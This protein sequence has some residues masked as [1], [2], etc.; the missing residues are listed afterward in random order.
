MKKFLAFLLAAGML[1]GIA[2]CGTTKDNDTTTSSEK[3]S[4]TTAGSEDPGTTSPSY[5]DPDLPKTFD[6]DNIVFSFAAISDMH[7]ANSATDT[8]AKKL[9]NAF[10]QLKK[11]ALID[12]EDGLDAV[13]AVGD[14][15]DSGGYGGKYSQMENYKAVYEK[16]FS[17][18]E[19]PM[20][21]VPG[22][23]DV[24]WTG[25]SVFSAEYLNDIL[26]EDYFLT[27]IDKDALAD[28]GNRHCVVNG[29]HVL[30]LLPVSSNPVT[31]TTATKEW[32]DETLA[33]ITKEN[34]NQFVIVLTHPMIYNTVYGS[35]LGPDLYPGITNMW[36]TKD[37]T[38]ILS[39]YN[40]VV[41]FGGHLHFPLNDPRSI[42]QTSFTSLGCGSV[43]YMAIE[44]GGYEDMAGVTTMLDKEEFSQG[45]LVQ[46]DKNGNMRITRMDFYNDEIIGEDWT[47]SYPVSDGS[48]LTKYAWDRGDDENNAAPTLSTL[49]VT[50][51]EIS[52]SSQAVSVSFASG[53]DDEFVHH[54][55]LAIW[56]GDS[57]DSSILKSYRILSDFYRHANTADMKKTW[58][59]DLGILDT[60]TSYVVA[61][62]AY[63]SWGAK[64]A[65]LIKEF[66]TGS[67]A[68]PEKEDLPEAYADINFS[69]G[70]IVD[71]KGN[72]KI[73]NM[74]ATVGTTT[75]T[76]GAK[77]A[78]VTALRVAA[79]GEY[80]LCTFDKLKTE[81]AMKSWA[82]NGFSVEAFYVMGQ[83]GSIQGVVCGTESGGWGI[84][85]DATGKPYFITGIAGNKYNA[86]AYAKGASSE[87]ELVHVVAVYDYKNKQEKIYINGVLNDTKSISGEYCPGM[88]EAFNKFCLGND[89]KK[90][91][92]GG[93]F[94]CPDMTMV[95]AKIYASA[96]TGGQV[97]TAYE[98]AIDSLN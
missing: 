59:K 94:A 76:V 26:G 73:Q 60:D 50:L 8:A 97:R 11:Q 91:G 27:D 13:F 17:P 30:T 22:N 62:V 82:E 79:S 75:V 88:S 49:D 38:E 86:G 19:T 9:E 44:A 15:I 83:K 47:V 65:Q 57:T 53:A 61:L 5:T 16:T 28:E 24:A 10:A 18:T 1:T 71:T 81:A 85:E 77:T 96:L 89:I 84:A 52:G 56:K 12:D 78:S 33:E 64:S 29:F 14:L 31:Y 40:Q 4:E 80:V 7:I 93:D 42:M 2:A 68:P 45:L 54:Y 34:P 48:H 66:K 43:R 20:I 32:L 25:S 70:T 69:G 3:P 23:H 39:K 98:D 72:I 46:I 51:G 58:E 92:M 41:T 87:T 6:S 36:Y 55:E 63:D 95:D 21:F 74:G 37:L 90:T 67:A 35:D